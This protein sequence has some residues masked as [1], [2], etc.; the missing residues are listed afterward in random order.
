MSTNRAARQRQR[1]RPRVRPL[2]GNTLY[3]PQA[4]PARAA[5]ERRSARPLLFLHQLPAWVAPVVAVVLLIA[6]LAARGPVGAVCLVG[7]AAALGWL[8]SMSWPRLSAGGRAG[9]LVI[10]AAMLGLAAWQATR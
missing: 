6:G 10:V 8:A 4:S 3:T 7:V 9:R 1:S 2:P 5:A